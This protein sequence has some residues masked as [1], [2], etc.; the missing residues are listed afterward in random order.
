MFKR[1]Q[2][3]RIGMGG[4]LALA[5]VGGAGYMA[6]KLVPP[7]VNNFQFDNDVQQETRLST[8]NG[9]SDAAIRKKLLGQAEALDLPL[10]LNGIAVSHDGSRV[11]V[12]AVYQV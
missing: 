7:M 8:Y 4:L 2:A 5:L 12:Q 11:T 10:G 6:Y 3:G 1:R 9:D